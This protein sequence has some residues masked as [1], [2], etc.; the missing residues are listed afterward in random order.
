[1]G[2]ILFADVRINR[3][4]QVDTSFAHSIRRVPSGRN[5]EDELKWLQFVVFACPFEI[6]FLLRTGMCFLSVSFVNKVC[7]AQNQFGRSANGIL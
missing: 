1:M 5:I 7:S 6:F 3:L 2:E 4:S